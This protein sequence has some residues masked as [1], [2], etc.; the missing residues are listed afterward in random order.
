MV[1]SLL[2]ALLWCLLASGGKE[3]TG[4][5]PLPAV[6]Q[7]QVRTLPVWERGPPPRGRAAAVRLREQ[8]AVYRGRRFTRPTTVPSTSSLSFLE[9]E[10]VSPAVALDYSNRIHRVQRF[11]RERGTSLES[12]SDCLSI[13]LEFCDELFFG[14][15]PSEDGK[16]SSSPPF[17][18]RS[19]PRTVSGGTVSL[20][21][22]ERA[23]RGWSRHCPGRT[24]PPLPL[25]C[26]CLLAHEMAL[27][28]WPW[29]GFCLLLGFAP[30][31]RPGELLSLSRK[32]L[33]PPVPM[34]GLSCWSIVFRL[35]EDFMPTKSGTFDEA[36]LVDGVM[37]E[38]MNPFLR[39]LFNSLKDDQRLLP[40][41]ST[42]MH[43][44]VRT[45]VANLGLSEMYIE[46]Y[47]VRHGGASHDA[48]TK[49]RV[50]SDIKKRLRHVQDSTVKRY[51]KSGRL[52]LELKKIP[53]NLLQ[54]GV[55]LSL[56]MAKIFDAKPRK[57][58]T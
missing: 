29:T 42:Q 3:F 23:V 43:E 1:A 24:R 21:R 28:G 15:F 13:L 38:W 32:H 45:V 35:T 11:F 8:R 48:V 53:E 10:A 50:T 17:D 27:C 7:S 37:W 5:G 34:A 22:L 2:W 14:G 31:L 55:R 46:W 9:T 16:K 4:R 51:E 20:A 58:V 44:Q 54:R 36:L 47:S 25:A 56:D 6:A 40:R 33:C 57:F 26:A 12:C 39:Q 49:V 30:Y 19:P 18:I 41:S 52:A